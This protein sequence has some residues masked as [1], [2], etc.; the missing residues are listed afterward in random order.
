MQYRNTIAHDIQQLTYDL[1]QE[2]F[3]VDYGSDYR[4][5]YDYKALARL[6]TYRSK[7]EKGL[8]RVIAVLSFDHLTFEAAEI[9][10]ITGSHL[11]SSFSTSRCPRSAAS[12][13]SKR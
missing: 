5:K 3:A 11:I 2:R 1:S 8:Q 13:S 10:A 4:T 6:K 7:I 12:T 9:D